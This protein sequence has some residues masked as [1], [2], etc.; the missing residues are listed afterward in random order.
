MKQALALIVAA[1]VAVLGTDPALANKHHGMH[2]ALLEQCN[3]PAYARHHLDQCPAQAM[4]LSK[5]GKTLR[6]PQPG[7]SGL[8]QTPN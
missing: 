1:V 3:Y 5:Q 6:K 4:M 2:S 7:P 8:A